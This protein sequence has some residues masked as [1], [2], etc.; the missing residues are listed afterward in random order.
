M[1]LF[2]NSLILV[3]YKSNRAFYSSVT[4]P[5]VTKEESEFVKRQVELVLHPKC[6]QHDPPLLHEQIFP[7]ISRKHLPSVISKVRE[8]YK[9]F[10]I[11]KG[12]N[13]KYVKN[14]RS[15]PKLERNLDALNWA[16]ITKEIIYKKPDLI[17]MPPC[18]IAQLYKLSLMADIG[19]FFDYFVQHMK[20]ISI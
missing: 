3:G 19:E 9:N 7:P 4:Y 17:L 11:P 18:D 13:E 5:D 1:K 15:L 16:Q 10:K 14:F 2:K 20:V 12:D 6:L 8:S